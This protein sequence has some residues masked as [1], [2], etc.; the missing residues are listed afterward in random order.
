MSKL[1]NS[2][3]LLMLLLLSAIIVV[4]NAGESE[5]L[6][7]GLISKEFKSPEDCKNENGI[8]LSCE[9]CCKKFGLHQWKK[10][11]HG[12]ITADCDCHRLPQLSSKLYHY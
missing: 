9:A 5:N 1:I 7:A 10:Y 8:N 6:K 3:G 4:I 11:T 2:W 12:I